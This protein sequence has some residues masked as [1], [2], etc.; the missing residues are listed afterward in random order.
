[1]GI[2]ES[3]IL[4]LGLGVKLLFVRCF[5]SLFDPLSLI[6]VVNSKAA[7]ESVQLFARIGR[8]RLALG[9]AASPWRRL[10]LMMTTS[11]LPQ[12]KT[13]AHNICVTHLAPLRFAASFGNP[14]CKGRI[15]PEDLYPVSC[16]GEGSPFWTVQ[17]MCFPVSFWEPSPLKALMRW[18]LT[19][20]RWLMEFPRTGCQCREIWDPV[21]HRNAEGPWAESAPECSES[22]SGHLAR[23]APENALRS[24]SK[25]P[26]G[27]SEHSEGWLGTTQRNL[28]TGGKLFNDIE[29]KRSRNEK[30]ILSEQLSVLWGILGASIIKVNHS[31]ACATWAQHF[32]IRLWIHK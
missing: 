18:R 32:E 21:S 4:W 19:T 7:G 12:A 30:A 14:H 3:V 22:A 24:A 8:L 16:G 29:R 20:P 9:L 15:Y 27:H 23:S 2:G 1:M 31:S 6:C 25:A 17:T 28:S 5:S 11:G 13:W 10:A 26:Q